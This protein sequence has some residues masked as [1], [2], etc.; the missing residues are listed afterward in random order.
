MKTI[1]EAAARVNPDSNVLQ[2]QLGDADKFDAAIHAA[3]SEWNMGDIETLSSAM[4]LW[5]DQIGPT[6]HRAMN[7]HVDVVSHREH[8]G[9]LI[10]QI[11]FVLA[12]A[13]L[14][15][16]WWKTNMSPVRE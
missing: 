3:A 13:L 6:A 9:K 10:F 4:M 8:I 14:A 12:S 15:I 1:V 5:A 7:T 11:T 2:V 16:T